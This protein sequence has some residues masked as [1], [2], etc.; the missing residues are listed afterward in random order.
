M[1][2]YDKRD[3]LQRQLNALGD[4]Q[5]ETVPAEQ[6]RA[7]IELVKGLFAGD[8]VDAESFNPEMYG[9]LGSLARFI[10][11]AR[12]ELADL[13][14]SELKDEKLP[15]ASNQLDAVVKMTE[16][17][18]QQIMDAGEQVQ[19]VHSRIRERLQMMDPPLDPDVSASIEDSLAEADTFVTGIFE[20]CNF[21]D[22]TGQRI[23]KIVEI[24]REVERQVF[25]MVIVFGLRGKAGE[26]AEADKQTLVDDAALL[27]GPSLEGEGLSQDD[28]D[29]VLAKLL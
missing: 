17:A 24:L 27:N 13:N 11:Q 4:V 15:D 12:R 9:E 7:L 14:P 3:E 26:L 16:Q 2:A 21:Q 5:G 22:I 25:R 28:I 6:V 19:G 18:T 20:A 29:D 1:C 10:G 23:M 8:T